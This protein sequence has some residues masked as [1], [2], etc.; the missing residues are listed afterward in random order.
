MPTRVSSQMGPKAIYAG[1][2]RINGTPTGAA[3]QTGPKAI[4]A[5]KA[6]INGTPTRAAAQ[7]GPKAIPAGKAQIIY[8]GKAQIIG[9]IPPEADG[10]AIIPPEVNEVEYPAYKGPCGSYAKISKL[11][12][13]TLPH[14]K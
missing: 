9:T 1:K 3:A 12:K 11:C 14:I 7:T 13:F 4:Y 10:K 5:G 6:Q 2:A 8:A